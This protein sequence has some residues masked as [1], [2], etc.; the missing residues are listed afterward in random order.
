[1]SIPTGPK[2]ESP[3]SIEKKIKIG[4][5]FIFLLNKTGRIILSR[6][7]SIMIAQIIKNIA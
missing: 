7:A 2:K 3:P 6:K 4:G 5:I 1:M